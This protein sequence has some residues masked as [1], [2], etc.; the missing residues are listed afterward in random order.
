MLAHRSMV[1]TTPLSQREQRERERVCVWTRSSVDARRTNERKVQG[2]SL[3]FK[4]ML[5][6]RFYLKMFS[7]YLFKWVAVTALEEDQFHVF[8]LL[9]KPFDQSKTLKPK[10]IR[11][12]EEEEE[13]LI[14]LNPEEDGVGCGADQS[15]VRG[16]GGESG[17]R[18][19]LRLR[20]LE[21]HTVLVLQARA[22]WFAPDPARR[23]PSSRPRLSWRCYRPQRSQIY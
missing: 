21:R 4:L 15:P 18:H 5:P 22:F 23:N 10:K 19:R 2:C 17:L 16:G 20:P 8:H 3:Y 13:V 9:F 1:Q 7:L 6:I 12:F 14:R 11:S